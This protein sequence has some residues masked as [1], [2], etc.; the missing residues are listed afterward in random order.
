MKFRPHALTNAIVRVSFVCEFAM[1]LG[2]QSLLKLH[3]MHD[4][5]AEKLP[6][7]SINRGFTITVGTGI[8][9]QQP[10]LDSVASVT[11]E[12]Y[13]RSGTLTKAFHAFPTMML[14]INHKYDRWKDI[15]P[16][17]R[18]VLAA[19]LN[20]V[21]E[22]Q[23]QAFGLEYVDRFTA[24]TSEGSLD[25]TGLLNSSSQYLVPRVFKI[26][27]PWHSHHGSLRDDDPSPCPHSKNAN[28]NVDLVREPGSVEQFAVNMIL[29]HR[30]VS[31]RPQRSPPV[32]ATWERYSNLSITAPSETRPAPQ[33]PALP[34]AMP[35]SPPPGCG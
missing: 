19:A 28:I 11:F 25:V 6:K 10:I 16:E 15:W 29:R 3:A 2:E 20:A 33:R 13:G 21:P 9:Q 1:P 7:V 32:S 12:E 34:A 30:R 17:A 5:F 4:R 22:A 18:N 8:V 26:P 23:V 14:F 24:P 27:G 31:C 35:R